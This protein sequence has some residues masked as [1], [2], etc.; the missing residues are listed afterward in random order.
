MKVLII[1]LLII[2]SLI[3][4]NHLADQTSPYLLQHKDN[5]VSWYPWG[6]EA[7]KK[8]KK[9]NKLIFLSIGYSTCHWCHVMAKESFEDQEIADI[10][11][12][13]YISIKVDKE[14]YPHIDQ[15]YQNIYRILNGK[16][17]GWPLTIILTSS[18]KPIFAGTYIPKYQGYGSK[19][20]LNILNSLRYLP[21]NQLEKYSKAVI[22]IL[23][24]QKII[25]KVTITK[26][27]DKKAIDQFK[28]SFDSKNG[29]FSFRP[30]FPQASSI[31]ILLD[32][33][34]LK[35]DKDSLNMALYT[36]TSMAKSGIYD[37]IDGGFFRYCTDEKWQIPHFEKMLYTNA[38]LVDVY[39]KAYRLTHNKLFKTVAIQT[40][41]NIDKRFQIDHLYKSASNADSLNFNKKEEE[42]FYF[43]Y[44]YNTIVQYLQKHHIKNNIIKENL[45]Y[46]GIEKDGNIDGDFSNPHITQT[47]KPKDLKII[48]Q[49]LKKYRDEK[50]YP[51]IDKKINLA[52]NCL[53]ID[54]KLKASILDKTFLPQALNSLDILIDKFYIK[55]QLYHQTIDN[56]IPTQKGLLEDYSFFANTLFSA[57][58]I[59]LDK[60]YYHLFKTIVQESIKLFYKNNKWQ[61]SNDGFVSFASISHSAYKN[62]LAIN[63]I[64]ILKYS[65]IE[66]D[67]NSYNIV[68]GSI[69]QFSLKLNSYPSYY[70]SM[71][72][73][74]LMDQYSI[75]VIKSNKQNLKNI[76][77][78]NIDFPFV[79]KK[80]T[81]DNDYLACKLSSCFSYSKDFKKVKDD[82][83]NLKKK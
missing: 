45:A 52:W 38:E 26:N 9:E 28:K 68:K 75:V 66:A 61:N 72:K 79:Y 30:K 37:Q 13:S 25:Q 24:K 46:L 76:D 16:G 15:Y 59:T 83:E 2:V 10:L 34:R 67:F 71:L 63:L 7:F 48:K 23:N 22:N 41:N 42:G 51:F 18:M 40:I 11:N 31:D 44:D 64:N 33:Y 6:K 65:V 21:K 62:P 50:K 20:L 73:L 58:E 4:Q 12:K 8:A 14:Q 77:I 36:L 70:P 39:T 17:G 5:P 56:L 1:F 47:T 43:I 54:A 3:G 55:N 53:F 27:I 60:K 81:K 82:I 80:V 35:D 19:G 57:Y 69:D 74:I 78:N 49:L 29:G 32:M